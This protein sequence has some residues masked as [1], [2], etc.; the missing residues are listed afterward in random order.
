M[1]RLYYS[2]GACSLAAHV[3]LEELGLPFQLELRSALKGV[4]T[5]TPEYLSINPKGRVPALQSSSGSIG[6]FSGVLTEL[7]AILLFLAFQHPESN[8][9]PREPGALARCVEW[10]NWL[11]GTVHTLAYGQIW[12]PQRVIEDPACYP[13]IVAKGMKN[14]ARDYAFIEHQLKV[15]PLPETYTIV[16]PVLLVFWLWGKW[17]N[18]DMNGGYPVWAQTIRTV[19]ERPAVRRALATEGIDLSLFA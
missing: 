4:G 5:Q 7:P 14:V 11:S 18:L 3:V 6:G 12:R 2:P 19:I 9:A 10:L 15:M 17:I 8:L 1:Y 16:H 13:D